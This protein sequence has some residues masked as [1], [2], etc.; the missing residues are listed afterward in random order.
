VW[1][2]T[3]KSR[4]EGSVSFDF[5]G[6]NQVKV[7][8]KAKRR[9]LPAARDFEIQVAGSCPRYVSSPNMSELGIVN[10][11]ACIVLSVVDLLCK[12][13]KANTRKTYHQEL[14]LFLFHSRAPSP[15]VP[16][17]ATKIGVLWVGLGEAPR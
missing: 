10:Y 6:L 11:L 17:A 2:S 14:T 8:L 13:I 4:S 9:F 1:G 3:R 7:D 5:L 15:S 12:I 16:T